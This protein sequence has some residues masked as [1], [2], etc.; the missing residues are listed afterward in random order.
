[1]C[2]HALSEPVCTRDQ[3]GPQDHRAKSPAIPAEAPWAHPQLSDPIHGPVQPRSAELP[4]RSEVPTA[5]EPRR[6]ERRPAGLW[7]HGQ[8]HKL[9]S[10][11][12]EASWLPVLQPPRGGGCGTRLESASG[13]LCV[14]VIAVTPRAAFKKE[15][16]RFLS[17]L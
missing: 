13:V 2:F 9:A 4:P 3:L 15:L 11:A 7:P 8:K 16:I 6:A 12:T 1:M 5:A 17:F 14:T 10:V